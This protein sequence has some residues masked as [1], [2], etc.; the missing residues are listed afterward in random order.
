MVAEAAEGNEQWGSKSEQLTQSG[1]SNAVCGLH[2]RKSGGQ[3][4]S[5][6]R[7]PAWLSTKLEIEFEF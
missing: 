1:G 2:I 6:L 5:W 7:E 3:L 4:T